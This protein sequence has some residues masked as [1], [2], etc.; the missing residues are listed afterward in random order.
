M[1]RQVRESIFSAL[2]S[3]QRPHHER[4]EVRGPDVLQNQHRVLPR[5]DRFQDG[6]E[7]G[8]AGAQNQS[9]GLDAVAVGNLETNR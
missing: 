9:V 7:V 8:A 3:Y 1:K 6:V 4:H 5:A 2:V